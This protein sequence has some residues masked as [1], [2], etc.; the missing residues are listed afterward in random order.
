MEGCGMSSEYLVG[1]EGKWW[2]PLVTAWS[3]G[4]GWFYCQAGD[5]SWASRA[6]KIEAVKLERAD[7]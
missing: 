1:T 5:V 7:I 2:C 4:E 3:L 6:R